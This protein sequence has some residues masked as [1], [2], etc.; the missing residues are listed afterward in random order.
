MPC[1]T[2]SA[3]NNCAFLLMVFSF[4]L[5]DILMETFAAVTSITC[6]NWVN[7]TRI[8]QQLYEPSKSKFLPEFPWTIHTCKPCQPV[9]LEALLL[10][11]VASVVALSLS[12][13]CWQRVCPVCWNHWFVEYYLFVAVVQHV[14]V[15]ATTETLVSTLSSLRKACL[16]PLFVDEFNLLLLPILPAITGFFQVKY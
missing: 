7:S 15:T 9:L 14:V 13:F 16:W 6:N 3:P 4:A 8:E 11:T 5:V 12:A 2:V 10:P 1:Y